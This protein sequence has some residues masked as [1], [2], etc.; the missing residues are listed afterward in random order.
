MNN[1]LYQAKTKYFCA[2]V[3]TDA[4][5]TITHAAPILAWSKGKSVLNLLKWLENKKGALK[6]VSEF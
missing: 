6:L 4:N 2:G 3:I 5:K 1:Y